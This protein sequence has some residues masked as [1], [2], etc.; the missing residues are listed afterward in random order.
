[1]GKSMAEHLI[2]LI[3]QTAKHSCT[4]AWVTLDEIKRIAQVN[5]ETER[6]KS[7]VDR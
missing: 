7:G 1:M 4:D 3:N 2:K 6:L 5:L